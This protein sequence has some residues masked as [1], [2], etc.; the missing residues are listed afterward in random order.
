MDY[1]SWIEGIDGFASLYSF[2]LL[3]DGSYSE[4]R[5][6]AVNK[7]NVVMLQMN[8]EA[9]EF[10]PGIPYRNYWMDLNFED[11]V[12]K[13][14]STSK[15][16]YSYVN[17]RGLWLKGFYIPISNIWD[18]DKMPEAPAGS[19]RL[20]CLY[21][22][23][24][25]EQMETD[26]MSLKTPEIASAVLNIGIK[27]HETQNFYQAI[28]DVATQIREF[29]GAERCAL[30][31]VDNDT[32]IC[33]FI[34]STGRREQFMEEIARQ[35]G[36]TPFEVA[37]AWED[38]LALSD[39]LLV[40]D[41][42]IIEERDPVWHK[43]LCDY[44]IHNI[45]LYAIRYGQTLVGFI[46]AANYDV[47]RSDQIKET[48]ELST[49]L[50]AAVIK[51]HQLM[52]KLEIKSTVDT[53]TQ[54]GN[55]NAMDE[56]I[57]GLAQE[58]RKAPESMAVIFTDLNGLK[59]ANDEKGHDA[60]DKLLMR[61]ASLLKIVFGDNQIYRIGGDEFVV[62]CPDITE[63]K[64]REQVSQLKGMA[65]NTYD[66]SFAVGSVYCHGE[67]DLNAAIQAADEQMYKDKKEYYRK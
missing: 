29:C 37:K 40:D 51:N 27:L 2:D 38:D 19:K 49:F 67:Y 24:F 58:H 62:L 57:T 46:W 20:F 13:C 7:Q 43:S 64:M 18:D 44:G 11:Y 60:G 39:C 41:F 59:K 16:L 45:I 21:V 9:P 26:S 28:T 50:L 52:S 25:S 10:Y 6:M 55:R 36:R 31:T 22:I 30:Y 8:P 33:S 66:V 56:Y 14:A 65:D 42:H 15:P 12:Y 34:D 61:A 23:T 4:I 54:V 3:E 5:L 63:E 17:A 35:M 47:T 32:Q 53:L 1:Q 48:L